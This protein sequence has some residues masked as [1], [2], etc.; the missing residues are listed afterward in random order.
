MAILVILTTFIAP[1]HW[2]ATKASAEG[3]CTLSKNGYCYKVWLVTVVVVCVV[4]VGLDWML[5]YWS[6]MQVA[7]L[8]ESWSHFL[9]MM[10][11]TKRFDFFN[12]SQL[13]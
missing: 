9:A 1:N 4:T 6:Y 12:F 11:V 10:M 3:T 5:V 7:I 8:G 2:L 13:F